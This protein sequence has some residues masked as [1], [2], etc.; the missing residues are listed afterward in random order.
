MATIFDIA[1][2]AGVSITTVSRA[3][4]G[5]SDVNENTRQ[6]ILAIAEDLKSRVRELRRFL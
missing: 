4:N 5:Y 1:K 2:K 6:T 3:L